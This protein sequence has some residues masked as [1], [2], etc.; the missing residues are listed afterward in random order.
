MLKQ[1][2]SSMKG[3]WVRRTAAATAVVQALRTTPRPGAAPDVAVKLHDAL[4]AVQFLIE[5]PDSPEGHKK[6]LS[7]ALQG[8]LDAIRLT[9]QDLKVVRE[10]IEKTRDASD[11]KNQAARLRVAL[12]AVGDPA[13]V[14]A[15]AA[16][17]RHLDKLHENE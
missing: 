17:I 9:A 13:L 5:Q 6:K 10:L 16:L 12:A 8:A 7:E 1:V 4:E 2:I 11:P 14:A 15:E 3:K